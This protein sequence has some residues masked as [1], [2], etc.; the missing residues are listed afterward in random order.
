MRAPPKKK[1]KFNLFLSDKISVRR[2]I[3]WFIFSHEMSSH[4]TPQSDLKVL[5]KLPQALQCWGLQPRAK[6]TSL[7]GNTKCISV[8]SKAAPHLLTPL[9]YLSPFWKVD[10]STGMLRASGRL[11]SLWTGSHWLLR[12]SLLRQR[13]WPG[14]FLL[15]SSRRP[16]LLSPP[17]FP[18]S[19]LFLRAPF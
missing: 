13:G 10:I 7:E 3:T 14:W 6:V 1:P 17:L 4:Y 11:L 8:S 15:V 18:F 5:I 12:T 2:K 16:I 19:F 9:Q